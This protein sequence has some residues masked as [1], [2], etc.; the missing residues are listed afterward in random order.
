MDSTELIRKLND[1]ANQSLGMGLGQRS[2][3]Q[4]QQGIFAR[5]LV[6][7]LQ[8]LDLKDLDQRTANFIEKY[9]AKIAIDAYEEWHV[10]ADPELLE[11]RDDFEKY[12]RGPV[13]SII[14]L[15]VGDYMQQVLTAHAIVDMLRSV[16]GKDVAG[17]YEENASAQYTA[18]Q[19]RFDTFLRR[20]YRRGLYDLIQK[21]RTKGMQ[22]RFG[23]TEL[24]AYAV[25]GRLMFTFAR[26]VQ[27]ARESSISFLAEDDDPNAFNAGVQS[28]F[29][30]LT[31]ALAMID[32][33]ISQ[34]PRDVKAQK[35]IF[36]A[37]K[38]VMVG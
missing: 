19:Q 8:G 23:S 34:W 21:S 32:D 10:A 17:I 36:K 27:H 28:I 18:V 37:S 12:L 35:K 9:L 38:S 6:K 14:E 5:Y 31:T 25:A 24:R 22:G 26:P 3:R 30:D 29:A 1:Y 2:P 13:P 16:C 11:L 4:C 7:Y 15:G 20:V 33:V